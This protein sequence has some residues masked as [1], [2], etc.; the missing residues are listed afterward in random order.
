MK[1]N[2]LLI[3]C[4]SLLLGVSAC[5]T[6]SADQVQQPGS[7][8]TAIKMAA[9][10]D[11]SKTSLDWAGMYTGS[12]PC[13]DCE[14]IETSV[15]LKKDSTYELNTKYRGK[16]GILFASKGSFSWDEDGGRITL[17][18]TRGSKLPVYQVGE[19][20]L[21]QVDIN[22]KPLSGNNAQRY[23]LTKVE[24][25]ITGKYWKPVQQSVTGNAAC[26]SFFGSYEL[27][28]GNRIHFSGIASTKMACPDL[29]TETE[30]LNMLGIADNYNIH[31]DTLILN[32]AKMAPLAR[33]EVVYLR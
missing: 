15:L 20:T 9:G 33:F 11:N 2:V 8:S 5:K 29:E 27:K 25:G 7:P 26:N 4:V 19:N 23:V 21:T 24:A 31:E 13:L 10:A 6:K 3:G 22:G 18:D 16:P 1:T 12:L 17:K 32:K 28:E 14:G 30:F